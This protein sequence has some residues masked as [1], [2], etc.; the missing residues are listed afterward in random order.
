MISRNVRGEPENDWVEI[1]VLFSELNQITYFL[2]LL[3][4]NKAGLLHLASSH[5]HLTVTDTSHEDGRSMIVYS[6]P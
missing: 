2:R 6:L 4:V 1:P 3:V 5:E